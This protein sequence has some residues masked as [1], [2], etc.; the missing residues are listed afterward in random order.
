MRLGANV[1]EEFPDKPKGMAARFARKSA[2]ISDCS[3]YRYELRRIWDDALPPYV[4]GMLNPS[5]ADSEIDDPTIIRTWRR[6]E[7]M[8]CGSLIVWNLGAGRAT[9]PDDWKAMADPIG[10]ENDAHIR[11]ILI[12][13]RER[14]GIAT[15]G[16]GAHG[17][18]LGR[19]RAILKIAAE[20]GVTFRC[21]GITKNGQPCHPLYIAHGQSLVE[22]TPVVEICGKAQ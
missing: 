11:R 4:S 1:L 22:W 5:K 20:V 19:D 17:S 3:R 10:P 8:G 18:F 6:A 9:D 14:N 15:V 21:L 16:W 12:E 2:T 7:A 13:C